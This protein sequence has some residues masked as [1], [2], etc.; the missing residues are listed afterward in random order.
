METEIQ[1][2]SFA[3]SD[4]HVLL[5]NHLLFFFSF[6]FVD[7]KILKSVSVGLAVVNTILGGSSAGLTVMLLNR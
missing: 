7:C 1:V 5:K 3:M 6:Y 4:F 2:H